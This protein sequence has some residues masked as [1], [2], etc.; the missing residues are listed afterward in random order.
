[1][2][3][4]N[5]KGFLLFLKPDIGYRIWKRLIRL[6]FS[7]FFARKQRMLKQN[8][9]TNLKENSSQKL[10]IYSFTCIQFLNITRG[11][12]LDKRETRIKIIITTYNA[13]DHVELLDK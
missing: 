9:K 13:F 3:A 8:R 5:S 10:V 7:I 6:Q 2:L 12:I 4:E 1:M 11:Y